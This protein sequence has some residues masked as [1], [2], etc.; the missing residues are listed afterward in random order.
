MK[1]EDDSGVWNLK[2]LCERTS[3]LERQMKEEGDEKNNKTELKRVRKKASEEMV[4]EAER[5]ERAR[6]RVDGEEKK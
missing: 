6:R 3:E 1:L 5:R 4:G 2:S